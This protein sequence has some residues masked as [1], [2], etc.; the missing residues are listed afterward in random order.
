MLLYTS[1]VFRLFVVVVIAVDC[2]YSCFLSSDCYV[3]C[4]SSTVTHFLHSLQMTSSSCS[5]HG[6]NEPAL[7]FNFFVPPLVYAIINKCYVDSN[8][9]PVPL[10]LLSHTTHDVCYSPIFSMSPSQSARCS[11]NHPQSAEEP[12]WSHAISLSL[13]LKFTLQWIIWSICGPVFYRNLNRTLLCKST[14]QLENY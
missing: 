13:R 4:C 14:C 2:D 5:I 10:S 12:S 8:I 1:E 11:N 7:R 6:A 9:Y 3:N